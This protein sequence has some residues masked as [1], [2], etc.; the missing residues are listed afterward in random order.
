MLDADL[1]QSPIGCG[2]RA[3][4]CTLSSFRGTSVSLSP[5][6]GTS[7]AHCILLVFTVHTPRLPDSS[8]VGVL[9]RLTPLLSTGRGGQCGTRLADRSALA[10]VLP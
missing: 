6:G 7:G 4:D 10:A 3:I 1:G 8:V 9:L 2:P 5:V